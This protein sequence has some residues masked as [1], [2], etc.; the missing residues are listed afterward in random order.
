M[1]WRLIELK[2]SEKFSHF[3]CPSSSSITVII[4][5]SVLKK[6]KHHFSACPERLIQIE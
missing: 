5:Y 3:P 4:M 6:F 1:K 2:M